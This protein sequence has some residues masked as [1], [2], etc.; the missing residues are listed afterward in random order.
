MGAVTTIF[1][2][3]MISVLKPTKIKLALLSLV[4]AVA[5]IPAFA[6]T[7]GTGGALRRLPW[8]R[9]PLPTFRSVLDLP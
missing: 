1:P 6:Q 2:E 9:L 4:I 5:A 3:E 8:R 7:A